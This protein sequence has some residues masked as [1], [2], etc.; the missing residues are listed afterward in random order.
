MSRPEVSPSSITIASSGSSIATDRE[1]AASVRSPSGMPS[2]TGPDGACE[3]RLGAEP[4]RHRGQRVAEGFMRFAEQQ[5]AALGREQP[6]RLV[7][8]GE[9]RHGLRCPDQ[10]ENV[11]L[12]QRRQGGVD[13]IGDPLNRDPAL[14]GLDPRDEDLAEKL[15]A[16]GGRDPAGALQRP[17]AGRRAAE[18]ET[19][20]RPGP[21]QGSR[22][23]RGCAPPA[24]PAEGGS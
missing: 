6:A 14:P 12:G 9:E 17:G 22:R 7:R 23:R 21:A 4:V 18:E 20:A 24:R 2:S 3:A 1:I 11:D 16:R 19:G 5:R 13:R 8:V 10:H 15:G